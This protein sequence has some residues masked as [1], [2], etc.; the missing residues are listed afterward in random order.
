MKNGTVSASHNIDWTIDPFNRTHETNPGTYVW[1][2]MW[3]GPFKN[4][5]EAKWAYREWS[6]EMN[7]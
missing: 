2:G 1:F 3:K 7:S 6:H 5:D 4:A